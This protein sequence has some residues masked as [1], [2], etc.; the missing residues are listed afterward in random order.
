MVRAAAGSLQ[1]SGVVEPDRTT[2]NQVAP[3]SGQTV[4]AVKSSPVHAVVRNAAGQVVGNAALSVTTG[5][6]DSSHRGRPA[7]PVIAFDGVVPARGGNQLSIVSGGK[8]VVTRTRSAH[9]PK[10]HLLSP[11][12]GT[13]GRKR[14]VTVRWTA[15]DADRQILLTNVD[16]SSDKGRHW[17][18]V[19]TT[20]RAVHSVK[21]ASRYF[22]GSKNARLRVRVS[23]GFNQVVST[24]GRLRAV[25]RAPNVTI[26]GPRRNERFLSD[27][28]VYLQGQAFDDAFRMLTGQRLTWFAGK[29]RLGHGASLNARGLPPGKVRLRLVA[30]DRTGRAGSAS[31]VV[32]V[33][34][35]RPFFTTLSAPKKL[36][37]KAGTLKLKVATNVAATLRAGGKNHAVASRTK[38]IR[39]K[40]KTGNKALKLGLRLTAHRRTATQTLAVPRG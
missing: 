23:D 36:S 28:S 4:R 5:H 34:A 33:S 21:L 3:A 18:A 37:R 10:A 22:T 11:R 7:T 26:T 30:R 1:V 40:V 9:A 13:M 31:V 27:A 12:R 24:S 20:D 19:Y 16:Y 38:T 29:R 32:R 6:L 35:A 17:H 39:V 15:S 8:T 14:T 2:I 25:G